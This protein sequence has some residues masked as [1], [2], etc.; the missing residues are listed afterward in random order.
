VLF[1]YPKYRKGD[2]LAGTIKGITIE[3][4]G[5]TTGLQQALQSTNNQI[6][7]TQ[8][9][10]KKVERLLKLDPTNTELLTQ[11]QTLLKNSIGET[12]KKLETLKEAEKQFKDQANKNDTTK[13]QYRDLQREIVETEQ[14]LKGLEKQAEQSNVTMQ[15]IGDTA[16]NIADKTRGLSMVAGT[17]LLGVGAYSF[18][19]ASDLEESLSKVDVVFGSSSKKIKDFSETTL[20]SYGIAKGSAL[21]MAALFGNMATSMG[22]SQYN[23]A[24]MSETLVKLS[25]DIASFQNKSLSQVQT[26]LK[27]I[28]TGETESLKEL[29]VIMTQANL[30]VFA[31]ANGYGK[32]SSEMNEAEK[33]QLR[34]QYV[35]E[36]TKNAQDDFKNTSDKAANSLRTAQEG[37][38]EAGAELGQTLL[39]ILTPMIQEVTRLTKA[40][41]DMSPEL[42]KGILAA[43]ALTAAI[44]PTAKA[45]QNMTSIAGTAKGVI[46]KMSKSFDTMS[47]SAK[48]AT[49]SIGLVSAEIAIL[50]A[51]YQRTA[52]NAINRSQKLIDEK[53]DELQKNSDDYYDGL[54]EQ[55]NSSND[56]LVNNLE[57]KKNQIQETYDTAI[58][59]ANEYVKTEQRALANEKKA[60]DKL[61]KERMEQLE[62]ERDLKLKALEDSTNA[63]TA[64][65]QS[66][67]D[68]LDAQTEAEEKAKEEQENAQRLTELKQA[69]DSAKTYSE[70]V[71]AQKAYT[72][73]VKKQE[74]AKTKALREEQKKQLQDRITQINNEAK[75]KEIAINNEY[76]AQVKLENDK[77]TA[78]EQ[79]ISDRLEALDGY[80]ESV[81]AKQEAIRL[82]A[83][84][85]A[86]SETL[87][88]KKEVDA[89]I[90]EYE[91][92]Q[93]EADK[94][95]EKNK[96]LES[97]MV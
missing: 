11:K 1:L 16:G 21:D 77:T 15:K 42:K 24:K 91:R 44:S 5:N 29:G 57:N 41:S 80:V 37:F 93:K 39:P 82:S 69:I 81:T 71:E 22:L 60:L 72:E 17:A 79:G 67:I 38:K 3:I 70:K 65:L 75:E 2:N 53:F 27:G 19:M 89:R 26:G 87:T 59:K 68:A 10:L 32:V 43:T 83:Q 54:I 76:N 74:E 6:R 20:D 64:Q 31:L 40:F 25:G 4:G 86:E 50:Y 66:Q 94:T 97:L 13:E 58:K 78:Q 85:K 48:S 63:A 28:F 56:T 18:K 51:L 8:S 14:S 88:L 96:E 45:I 61:H 52:S 95:I 33:V 34:Y 92:Q 23:S 46:E 73:E 36:K 49:K 47:V 84:E 12:A 35:L 90:A 7:D 62:A 55:E 9:E 30:D